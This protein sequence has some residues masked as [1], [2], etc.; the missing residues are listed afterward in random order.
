MI[1]SIFIASL[2]LYALGVLQSEGMLL[3]SLR[4]W[5]DKQHIPSLVRKPLYACSPCMSSIWGSV[6]WFFIGEDFFSVY[7]PLFCL[8][9]C[10]STYILIYNFPYDE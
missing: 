4:L 5:L 6:I 3:H 8:S 9:V 2:A 1:S 7:W 10:G